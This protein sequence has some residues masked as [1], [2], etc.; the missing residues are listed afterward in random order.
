MNDFQQ[1]P[2]HGGVVLAD[3]Q[4]DSA[5]GP[6]AAPPGP[7]TERPPDVAAR[8]ALARR[9]P[10][11]PRPETDTTDQP[12]AATDHA[13]DDATDDSYARCGQ[14]ADGGCGADDSGG[15]GPARTTPHE[16]HTTRAPPL[17]D[18]PPAARDT[19][20][21][22]DGAGGRGFD[23]IP[24]LPPL[25]DGAQRVKGA[26]SIFALP[27]TADGKWHPLVHDIAS[28]ILGTLHNLELL[29]KAKRHFTRVAPGAV[30]MAWHG[31]WHGGHWDKVVPQKPLQDEINQRAVGM[32]RRV[33][34]ARP[35]LRSSG[36]T[37]RTWRRQPGGD[38]A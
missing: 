15:A 3:E 12:P 32:K 33:Q 16:K 36:P 38:A 11:M 25:P 34:R 28:H 23:E 29:L 13:D 24:S 4:A 1:R 10:R 35:L 26:P 6:L 9:E 19:D 27:P 5:S 2:T 22:P 31:T 37:D 21:E 30:N 8:A 17:R 7:T 14:P 20:T 18:S